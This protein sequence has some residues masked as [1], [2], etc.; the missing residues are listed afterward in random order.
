MVFGAK[1]WVVQIRRFAIS[2][3]GKNVPR[4]RSIVTPGDGTNFIGNLSGLSKAK[5]L[6]PNWATVLNIAPY[7][8]IF[9]RLA[10]NLVIPRCRRASTW[11]R[12]CTFAQ[13]TTVDTTAFLL[14]FS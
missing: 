14:G 10:F 8:A 11:I 3:L 6:G 9:T 12:P 4:G 1:T 2:V 13:E 7:V 5:R